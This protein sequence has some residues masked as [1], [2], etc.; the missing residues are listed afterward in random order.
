MATDLETRLRQAFA[1]FASTVDTEAPVAPR[2]PDRRRLLP[3][4]AVAAA[5]VVLVGG[6]AFTLLRPSAAPGPGTPATATP[7]PSPPAAESFPFSLLT[8]CGVDEARIRGTYFEAQ[9]PIAGPAASAPAG[10][11]NPYQ[12]GTMTLLSPTTAVFHDSRG[13]E[14]RFR[15]RPGATAFKRPCD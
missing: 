11:D 8:H 4:L 14:V 7:V 5:V 2:V 3:V 12:T 10:W 6:L 1:A 9:T 13:H 15:A